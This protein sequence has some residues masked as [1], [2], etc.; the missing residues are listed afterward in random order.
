MPLLPKEYRQFEKMSNTEISEHPRLQ[1]LI[2]MRKEVA[3]Q[4][5]TRATRRAILEVALPILIVR[6]GYPLTSRIMDFIAEHVKHNDAGA[7]KGLPLGDR[8]V[9]RLL[10]RGLELHPQG[11]FG[12]GDYEDGSIVVDMAKIRQV[13]QDYEMELNFET[14]D[15]ELAQQIGI[16]TQVLMFKVP[17]SG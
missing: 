6:R 7:R 11:K 12:R 4:R 1:E 10:L 9:V 17:S 2:D 5:Y 8:V 3:Y 16:T 14:K 15:F 13:A